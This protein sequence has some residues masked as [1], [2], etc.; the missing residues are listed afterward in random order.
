VTLSDPGPLLRSILQDLPFPSANDRDFLNR[1]YDREGL[2][3]YA[4]RIQALGFTGLGRVLDAGCGFAQWS[5]V[6]A[7]LND[8][9]VGL[10]ADEFRLQVATRLRDGLGITNLSFVHDLLDT[11]RLPGADFDAIFCYNALTL[12]PYRK[13]L[14]AFHRLLKPGGRLYFNAADLGWFIQN[15][16]EEHHPSADFS[17]RTWAG[18]TIRNTIHY[19]A[20]GIFQQVSPRDSLLIPRDIVV[21]ELHDLGFRVLEVAGDGCIDRTG[22]G[23]LPF[24]PATACGHPAVY[25]VL[26]EKEIR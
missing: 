26:C 10:D 6:F 5:L 12:S 17:P 25:E 11:A 7:D 19:Y 2:A 23:P 1:V 16:L 3:R 22:M 21:Q 13:T 15:I 8:S 9:V 20:T 14:A 18:D 4:H 24:F